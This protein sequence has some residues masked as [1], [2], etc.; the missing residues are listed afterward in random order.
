MHAFASCTELTKYFSNGVLFLSFDPAFD[1]EFFDYDSHGLWLVRPIFP[2][3]INVHYSWFK[4]VG[5]FVRWPEDKL[6]LLRFERGKLS[7][8]HVQVA[9]FKSVRLGRLSDFKFFGNDL[10]N[11]HQ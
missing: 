1:S 6:D 4:G 7:T 9:A 10:L 11:L 3:F 2:G 5:S 8:F